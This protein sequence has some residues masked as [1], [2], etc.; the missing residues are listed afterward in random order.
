MP[1]DGRRGEDDPLGVERR[2]GV[3]QRLVGGEP[4]PRGSV[5]ERSG[6][7]LGRSASR[8]GLT[9]RDPSRRTAAASASFS[10]R[11][12]EASGQCTDGPPSP[13][14]RQEQAAMRLGGDLGVEVGAGGQVVRQRIGRTARP[15][16]ARSVHS[17]P[18]ARPGGPVPRSARPGWGP[19]RRGP[20]A[21]PRTRRRRR[22]GRGG[23]GEGRA[24]RDR[25]AP[26]R[27]ARHRGGD[28]PGPPGQP[29]HAADSGKV[30]RPRREPV[31]VGR[32]QAGDPFRG[33]GPEGVVDEPSERLVVHA[34]VRGSP[35]GSARGRAGAA[36]R[37]RAPSPRGASASST[38]RFIA[39]R[40]SGWSG[41]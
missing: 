33:L 12:V 41:W 28:R 6:R 32:A 40:T 16:E 5:G 1:G 35:A 2:Q 22:E 21:A 11:P 17:R 31:G 34:R 15:R 19:A 20:R 27:Q 26:P 30:L 23:Q 39:C 4:S 14:D 10:G 25:S 38:R 37:R 8:H 7:C 9:L 13:V 29:G 24:R 3:A 18:S 36:G